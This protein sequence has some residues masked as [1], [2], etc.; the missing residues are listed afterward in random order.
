MKVTTVQ[1]I[2]LI[3]Q[4]LKLKKIPLDPHLLTMTIVRCV[5][6][7]GPFKNVSVANSVDPDQTAPLGAV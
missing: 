4:F 5:P 6:S 3:Q 1:R 7:A 2:V